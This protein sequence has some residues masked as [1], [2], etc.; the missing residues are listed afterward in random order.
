[1]ADT[2]K[3]TARR[4]MGGSLGSR[5]AG[6]AVKAHFLFRLGDGWLLWRAGQCGGLPGR[7]ESAQNQTCEKGPFVSRPVSIR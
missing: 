7:N 4:V 2:P 6:V 5:N 1:M 3:V